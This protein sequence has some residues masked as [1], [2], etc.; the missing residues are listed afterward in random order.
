MNT[1]YADP[2][3]PC[4]FVTYHPD[5]VYDLVEFAPFL[6]KIIP[7]TPN[8]KKNTVHQNT[9]PAWPSSFVEDITEAVLYQ[10]DGHWRTDGYIAARCPLPHLKDRPGMHFSYH[11]TSGW[12]HCFGKHGKLSPLEMDHLLG[13]ASPIHHSTTAA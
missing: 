11:A 9:T 1:K 3:I 4:Q 2:A 5:R 10:L 8:P 13:I 12:G 6:P 7:W